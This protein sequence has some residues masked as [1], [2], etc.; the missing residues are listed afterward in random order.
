[1][2]SALLKLK[3]LDSAQKARLLRVTLQAS[4][5]ELSEGSGELREADAQRQGTLCGRTALPASCVSLIDT[6]IPG[7][8]ETSARW[9]EHAH[10]GTSIVVV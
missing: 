2:A 6:V 10:I 4:L 1:M 8:I 3:D 5:A 7:S 9:G